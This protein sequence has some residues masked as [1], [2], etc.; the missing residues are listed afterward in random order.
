MAKD[1]VA[2]IATGGKQYVVTPGKELIV[3]KLTGEV[4]A[5]MTFADLLDGKT[6]TAEIVSHGKSDKVAGRVFQNKVR[7]SRFPHGHRQQETRIRITNVA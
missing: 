3:E 5:A 4:G 1:Q 2:V 7:A 6:V